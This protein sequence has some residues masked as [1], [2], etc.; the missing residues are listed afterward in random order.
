MGKKCCVSR[1][2]GNF[3]EDNKASVFRLPRDS[4]EN[5]KSITCLMDMRKAFDT[6]QHSVLF[7]KLLEQDFSHIVVRY[8]LT[9]YRLQRANVKWNNEASNFF[10]IGNGV[11]QG[12][13]LSAVF[14][15]INTNGLFK[16]LRRLN[17]GCCI[18]QNNVGI[19]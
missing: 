4:A 7:N 13:V 12:A 5:E 2:H 16:E 3:D 11:K 15:C 9:T 6:V 10:E 8:L 19:I 1:C 18:G 14:Y 17:I